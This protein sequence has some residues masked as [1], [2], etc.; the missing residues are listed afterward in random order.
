MTLAH[1][2]PALALVLLLALAAWLLLREGHRDHT[3]P[4]HGQQRP[5]STRVGTAQQDHDAIE[6]DQP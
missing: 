2:A 4:G 3:R 1:H 5:H 6:G